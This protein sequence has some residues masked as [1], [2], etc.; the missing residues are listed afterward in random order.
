SS[1]AGT[2]TIRLDTIGHEAT[3]ATHGRGPSILSPDGWR[4]NWVATGRRN[5]RPARVAVSWERVVGLAQRAHAPTITAEGCPGRLRG[6]VAETPIVVQNEGGEIVRRVEFGAPSVIAASDRLYGAAVRDVWN[7]H[8]RLQ[9][10]AGLR[11]D[12]TTAGGVLPS[13][14]AGIRFNVEASG[15]SVIKAGY[16]SFVGSIPLAVE[17]FDRYPARVDTRIDARSGAPAGT[18][19]QP[20][21][22]TQRL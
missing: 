2:W 4:G 7:A 3:L 10:D 14:R 6:S 11:V 1:V 16:G 8:S 17:A 20:R 9:I 15:R 12:G 19:P 5:A 13:A 18:T 22:R 21:N